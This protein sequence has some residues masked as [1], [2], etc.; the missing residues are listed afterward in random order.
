MEIVFGIIVI[1]MLHL[2][3][4]AFAVLM[5]EPSWGYYHEYEA[6]G[7]LLLWPL[8]LIKN[9]LIFLYYLLKG[10][11]NLVYLPKI[12]GCGLYYGFKSLFWD[13]EQ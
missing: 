11:Y 4:G 2:V 7:I 5:A 6:L 1:I 10:S 8:F 9:I 3:I 13:W 12:I